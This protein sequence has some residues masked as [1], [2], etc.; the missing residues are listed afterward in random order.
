M[1][2][3]ESN[4][5]SC[6]SEMVAKPGQREGVNFNK[7]IQAWHLCCF[8]CQGD[9]TDFAALRCGVHR[10][11]LKQAY[12]TMGGWVGASYFTALTFMSMI[13]MNTQRQSCLRN[14]NRRDMFCCLH[15]P[16]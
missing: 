7:G 16:S 9:W 15:A 4:L 2:G 13:Q 12:V 14:K 11:F 10:V 3:F 5:R 8:P 6:K 1:C